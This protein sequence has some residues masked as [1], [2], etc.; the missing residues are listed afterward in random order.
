M[1]DRDDS[2]QDSA[3][4]SPG[5]GASHT[6]DPAGSRPVGVTGCQTCGASDAIAEL[7]ISRSELPSQYVYA[8]GRIEPRLPTIG[9]EKELA[10]AMG[11]AETADLTDR[12]ALHSVL[13][14][15]ANRYLAR[16]ACYIFRVHELD[17]YIVRPRDSADLTFLV[18]AVRDAPRSTDLHLLIG[19]RGGLAPPDLCNGT[20]LPLVAFDQIYTFDTSSLVRELPKPDD[21]ETERF[22]A[23]AEELF[24]RVMQITDNAGAT[25]EHRALNYLVVRYPRIYA[26]SAE[27]FAAGSSITAI[28]T[29]VSRL[30]GVRN[31]LDVIFSY[32][33]RS[34]DVTEKFFVRVDVT[35]EFPFLV[36]K[37]SPYYDR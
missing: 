10:Q 33:S 19:L 31:I 29:R 30:S 6:H 32:T 5:V 8:L 17:T 16:Q 14:E 37:L 21:I 13:A 18:D 36:T 4:S 7:T 12:Q 34:T 23:A 22:Q 15:P 9:L 3:T 20:V 26:K 35:E 28:E 11:R 1:D 24:E 2:R 25:D 27:A